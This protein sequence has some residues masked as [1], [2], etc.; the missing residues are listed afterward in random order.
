MAIVP[1]HYPARLL[2]LF[3]GVA[4]I[5]AVAAQTPPDGQLV[6]GGRLRILPPEGW[7]LTPAGDA[8]AI[9][10]PPD[11]QGTP[12]EIVGWDVPCG[13]EPSALAAATAQETL[14][15]RT[16]PYARTS[17]KD[18][19]TAAGDTGLLL[20]GQVKGPDGRLQE[21]VFAAFVEQ[22]RYYIVGTF[23]PEGAASVALEGPFGSVLKSLCFETPAPAVVARPAPPELPAP[24][25]ATA[26]AAPP[27]T[28]A[29]PATP[30]LPA[31]PAVTPLPVPQ[32]GAPPVMMALPAAA[33]T[34]VFA[35]TR[36]PAP[37]PPVAARPAPT[38]ITATPATAPS[39]ARPVA[40]P[41]A[42][43][44]TIALSGPTRAPAA[45]PP[46]ERPVVTI[47]PSAPAGLTPAAPSAPTPPVADATPAPPTSAPRLEP[48]RYV[49]PVG[50]ELE[51]PAGWKVAMAGGRIEV[52][53]PVGDG[54]DVPGAMAVIWPLTGISAGQ[55]A[56]AVARQVL[57]KWQGS[58]GGTA[59]LAARTRDE[60]AVLA[61]TVGP[62]GQQRRLIAC[63]QVKNDTGLLT[64]ILSRPEDLQANL[65]AL[66]MVL[67][68]FSGGP[69]W[70]TRVS[71]STATTLWRDPAAKVLQA[72]V[73]AGWKVRGGTQN[74][75]GSW[76]I[77]V[78]LTSTDARHL[79]V[80]WQQPLTPQYRELTTVLR[81]LGWQEGDKYVANAGDQPLRILSRLSP[82][83]FLTRQWLPNNTL[84]LENA[85]LDRLENEP[86]AAGLV[87][88]ANPAAIAA[89]LHGTSEAGPR[90][91]FCVIAT[92]DAPARTGTNCWQA[93][94]LQADAPVGALDEAL[95]VLRNV[96]AGA[97]LA[98]EGPSQAASSV[99]QLLGAAQRAL[100]VL[101]AA[102]QNDLV[103][104]EVL[105]TLA[106]KGRGD[107]WLLAPD[108]LDCWQ[109]AARRLQQGQSCTDGFPEIET[110]FWK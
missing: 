50:Y 60:T 40:Q 8:G 43:P 77:F 84:R 11:P 27:V 52:S 68:S 80:T 100:A 62:I 86:E 58:A 42:P 91:R 82:Q 41:A 61:G 66:T 15:F 107:L 48:V 104:Q 33:P 14:L 1:R 10:R 6:C 103:P 57:Q 2:I 55:D 73:P 38:A 46:V 44:V 47:Q 17:A 76:S 19:R 7:Q 67:G 95:T 56:T 23:A 92:A 20:V 63:C 83:D 110:A 53:S 109:W 98:P 49:S 28:I 75:N 70:T 69:W 26:P 59:A 101:P 16:S 34:P 87:A 24:P 81:N 105:G 36:V 85:V 97:E 89:Q 106:P 54:S 94:V 108:A 18:Y 22:G 39:P 13:G 99:R 51:H 79:S 96:I 3:V 72:A 78:D 25:A 93:A 102:K 37:A 45:A 71:G 30:V 29:L 90:Q 64:A 4:L 5:S 74:F 88:G 9:L 21:A 12:I 32:P 31:P 35:P 65:P